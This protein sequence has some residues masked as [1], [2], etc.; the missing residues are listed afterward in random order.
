MAAS[1]GGLAPSPPKRPTIIR[2][3]NDAGPPVPS[4]PAPP[5]PGG[6]RPPP[7][8]PHRPND[9]VPSRPQ[10]PP[11]TRPAEPVRPQPP[12]PTRP[13]EVTRPQPPPPSRPAEVSRTKPTIT[14][15]PDKSNN[16]SVKKR[17]EIT[18]VSARPMSE[19][20]FRDSKPSA[21]SNDSANA[22]SHPPIQPSPTGEKMSLNPAQAPAPA[23]RA[24]PRG[25]KQEKPQDRTDSRGLSR[26]AP[27]PV[28]RNSVIRNNV[29]KEESSTDIEHK[30]EEVKTVPHR[31]QPP[32]VP[33]P[34]IIKPNVPPSVPSGRPPPALPGRPPASPKDPHQGFPS[35]HL[36]EQKSGNIES[37]P[38]P[39]PKPRGAP[40][41][42][43]RNPSVRNKLPSPIVPRKT[44]DLSN[45]IHQDSH[46]DTDSNEKSEQIEDVSEL[47]AVINKPK[48][49]TIIRPGRP[50]AK[51]ETEPK[52]ENEVKPADEIKPKV[53][54]TPRISKN[55]EHETESKVTENS[56]DLR[57]GLS[58]N[59]NDGNPVPEFLR[60][61]LKPTVDVGD[62]NVD[63]SGPT[64]GGGPN[65][66]LK[67][68]P[69]STRGPPPA[70][71]PK[72]SVLPKPQ[73]AAK[74]Q[75]TVKVNETGTHKHI[76]GTEAETEK[77]EN[78]DQSVSPQSEQV[79]TE[80]NEAS[81]NVKPATKR[82]TIIRPSRSVKSGSVEN[83]NQENSSRKTDSD[84]PYLFSDDSAIGSQPHTQPPLPNKRPV[85]MINIHKAVENEDNHISE[86]LQSNSSRSSENVSETLRPKPSPR[87]AARSR[88]VTMIVPPVS[89]PP[90][91]NAGPK[92]DKSSLPPRPQ[93]RPPPKPQVSET[94]QD[95]VKDDTHNE[96][97]DEKPSLR[98]P[99][100]VSVLPRPETE[101]S[102]P[103][104]PVRRPPPPKTSAHKSS[105]SSDEE[106]FIT[107]KEKPDRPSAGP[108]R[109]VSASVR[110]DSSGDEPKKPPRPGAPPPTHKDDHDE[111]SVKKRPPKP[112]GRPHRPMSMPVK[113]SPPS[114][115]P[116]QKPQG[117]RSGKKG[118]PQLPQR[119]KPGHPLYFHMMQVP[120][121]IAV[122]EY[123]ALH[124]DELSFKTGDLI[125]FVRRVD[126]DWVAGKIDEREGMFPQDFVKVKMPLP[127]EK[128]DDDNSSNDSA[129]MFYDAS[130]E[131]PDNIGHGPRCRARFDF[132]GEGPD[133]L[134][135][136]EGDV[137]RL[138]ERVGLEW[139][140]GEINGRVGLFP[141]PFVEIIED[142]P[143]EE[144]KDT[145][146]FVKAIF[147][148]EGEEGDLNFQAG[149]SIKVTHMVN[150]EW[151]YG[152]IEDRKGQ[153]P[154]QFVDHVPHGLSPLPIGDA[155]GDSHAKRDNFTGMNAEDKLTSTLAMWDD[156]E[157]HQE[158]TDSSGYTPPSSHDLDTIATSPSPYCIALYDYPAQTDEDLSFREGDHIEIIER[159]SADWLK[160]KNGEKIGMFPSGFVDV[161]VDIDINAQEPADDVAETYGVA[162]YEFKGE[163]DKELTFQ[164]GDRFVVQDLVE[165][166]EDWRWGIKDGHRGMFPAAFV[167]VES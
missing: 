131:K 75:S 66:P 77:K 46:V 23:P 71:K 63:E 42:V 87:P 30:T 120:H 74:P 108:A 156:H 53:S 160:G 8:V 85:S 119:P 164:T 149:E 69:Q 139:R 101:C 73:V 84:K 29:E 130:A 81:Q 134:T 21:P 64:A 50:S 5:V 141:L 105:D 143:E 51:S 90:L 113:Q 161:K 6:A 36:S 152:E 70:T 127:G 107:A 102:G 94:E 31:G 80:I 142:L 3:S 136:E 104:K 7:A 79:R 135:F 92:I 126:S 91:P 121:G 150:E 147:D 2:Q 88:P 72:P 167:E 132:D 45:E 159:I 97:S 89:R 4:R 14:K 12:P 162:L 106:E 78:N 112:E 129:E 111:E 148:F 39:P 49:P 22:D 145:G 65:V 25:D 59:V 27:P 76:V 20:G 11:P 123:T 61:K 144:E 154:V 86:N 99:F 28:P 110:K 35:E 67:P 56:E 44:D 41:P 166:A 95:H 18:I 54:P 68:R 38:S 57:E 140:K 52:L 137:I 100:G 15:P 122:H 32:P 93:G 16:A 19:I 103:P 83:V 138:V 9:Q 117:L 60:K 17:P 10:P 155:K 24:S 40:P 157:D 96:L 158:Q 133:D 34:T 118:L 48:R 163:T 115:S 1:G 116:P 124:D 146:S 55:I 82:P 62:R 26:G 165:G 109:K 13:A 37:H 151:L 114:K 125:I 58:E 98:V 43:P 33:R 47:Y 153:F 128:L